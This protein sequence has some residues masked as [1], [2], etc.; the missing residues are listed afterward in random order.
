VRKP[1][2][3]TLK[4]FRFILLGKCGHKPWIEKQARDEFF[5]ILYG[6]ML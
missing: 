6:E 2:L 3:E 4:D 5:K 1:L